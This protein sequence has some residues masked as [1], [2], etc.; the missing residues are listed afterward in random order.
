MMNKKRKIKRDSTVKPVQQPGDSILVDWL[1][2][3]ESTADL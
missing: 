3:M 1:E 2:I